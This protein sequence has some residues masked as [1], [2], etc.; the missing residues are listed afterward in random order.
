MMQKHED[1]LFHKNSS[2]PLPAP[3]LVIDGT[4]TKQGFLD[5]LKRLEPKIMPQ[6]H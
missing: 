1:W 3:V 2:Y 6:S 4:L 5:E